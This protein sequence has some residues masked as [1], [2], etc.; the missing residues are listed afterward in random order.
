MQ[1]TRNSQLALLRNSWIWAAMSYQLHSTATCTKALRHSICQVPLPAVGCLAMGGAGN[2]KRGDNLA[3][4]I[5]LAPGQH[6]DNLS[7]PVSWSKY[8]CKCSC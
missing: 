2:D 3:V 5:P 4:A 6:F 7:G 1:I 8:A